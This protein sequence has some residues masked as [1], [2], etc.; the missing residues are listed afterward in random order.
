ML[1]AIGLAVFL[2]TLVA[3]V[4]KPWVDAG[5]TAAAWS[6]VALLVVPWLGLAGWPLYI[7][8]HKGNGP[9][10]D[11][12]LHLSRRDLLVGVVG[13]VVALVLATLVQTVTERVIGHPFDSTV[14]ELASTVAANRAAL[15]AFALCAAFGA[16]V[17]EEIAFRGLLY[18]SFR[19]FGLSAA[20]SV[21]YTSIAFAVFHLEGVRLPLLFVIGLVLTTVRAYTD[22]TGAS[23]VAHCCVNIPGAI[24]IL[25]LTS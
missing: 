11:F 24:A 6:I 7:A 20:F 17:V 13:G 4:T 18:G 23:I 5:A 21:L 15:V 2:G 14:G 25:T 19:K 16:P 8:R 22:S 1:I 12:R 9:V 3:A 10:S